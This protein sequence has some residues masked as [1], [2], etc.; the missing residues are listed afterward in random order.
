MKKHTLYW[1][2]KVKICRIEKRI[3]CIRD[4]YAQRSSMSKRNFEFEHIVEEEVRLHRGKI[5]NLK[6]KMVNIR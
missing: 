3:S 5:F 4:F 1:Y 6:R 2:Y